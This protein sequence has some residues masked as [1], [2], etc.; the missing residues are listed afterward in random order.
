L[1]DVVQ[2]RMTIFFYIDIYTNQND[3]K[4]KFIKNENDNYARVRFIGFNT[5][6]MSSL[7]LVLERICCQVKPNELIFLIVFLF[8]LMQT[9]KLLLQQQ[10]GNMH[11]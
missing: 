2:Q 3:L 8:E 4:W 11:L 7:V 6:T 10:D 1:L 9:T 5:S